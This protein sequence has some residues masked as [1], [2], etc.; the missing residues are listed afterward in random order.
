MFLLL[1]GTDGERTNERINDELSGNARV[2]VKARDHLIIG[3]AKLI[4]LFGKY[5]CFIFF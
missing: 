2:C 1:M 4:S 3:F 5:F